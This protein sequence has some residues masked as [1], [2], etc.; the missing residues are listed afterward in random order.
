MS[1]LQDL[2]VGDKV[3]ICGGG[4]ERALQVSTIAKIGK[5]HIILPSGKKYRKDSGYETGASTWAR[6]HAHI[7]PFNEKEWKEYQADQRDKKMRRELRDF[8]WSKADMD[9]VRA[10]RALLPNPEVA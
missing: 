2:K 6:F 8:D 7:E 3:L 10:V 5:L 9:L 4:W 1:V